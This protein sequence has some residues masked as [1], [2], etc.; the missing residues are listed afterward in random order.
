MILLSLVSNHSVV[1]FPTPADSA[2]AKLKKLENPRDSKKQ[3]THHHR[4]T[5]VLTNTTAVGTLSSSASRS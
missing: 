2:S 1:L 5:R 3:S 4:K